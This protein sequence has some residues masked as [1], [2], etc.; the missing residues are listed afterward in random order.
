MD[1][2]MNGWREGGREGGRDEAREFL[3]FIEY[4]NP[5]NLSFVL[6]SLKLLKLRLQLRWSHLHFI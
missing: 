5:E 2:W 3:V 4:E 1:G 6:N